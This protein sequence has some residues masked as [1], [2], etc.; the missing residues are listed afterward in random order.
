MSKAYDVPPRDIEVLRRLGARKVEIARHP[1]NLARKRLWYQLDE[2][3]PG[4]PLVLAE[5]HAIR[6]PHPPLPQSDLECENEW[7]RELETELRREIYQFD[8]LQDDHVVEPL[9]PVTWQTQA[10]DY[11][12]SVV[13]HSGDRDGQ[14][15]A[16]RW[17]PPLQD[18]SRDFAKLRPR[19]FSVDRA[20]SLERKA[21]LEQVFRGIIPVAFRHG[22][23][24]TMGM[25]Q[26][27]AGLLGLD[28]LMLCM[29]DNPDGFHRLMAF[30]RDDHLAYAR[31]LEKEGLLNLNNLNDYTGSGT[32][33]YS[34]ALP[35]PDWKEGQPVRMKD[36]WV[37]LE[38]QE[39]VGVGP[40][41]FEEFIFP[42][43]EAIARE[44]GRVYYGCCEPLNHRWHVVKRFSNLAR[45]SVSPWADQ[46]LMAQEL[47][48]KYVF[49]RKPSPTLISTEK[50][51][52][53][54]IRADLRYTLAVTQGLR[55]EIIMKDVHTL[56]NQPGRLPRWVRLAR[57]TI[58]EVA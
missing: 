46:K 53:D 22:Y 50:F 28:K 47:G 6:D 16:F 55:V 45:V 18:L 17:D 38:S 44:F 1:A 32:I 33:G 10:S 25:T 51:D 40:R 20:A 2:G 34:R 8:V 49:S 7:A 43:Q 21:R 57:E 56:H 30:L 5:A 14:M 15:G 11:G 36:G 23:W 13:K 9:M 12:V 27:V 39:T 37:L 26:V 41:Q 31:W 35:Q 29:M 4:R 58:E 52:E 19:T 54:A 42:Y 24:W 3:V 48:T